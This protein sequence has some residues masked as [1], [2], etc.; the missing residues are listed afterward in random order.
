M[1][2]NESD[3]HNLKVLKN[4]CLQRF[5]EEQN[6]LCCDGLASLAYS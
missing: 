5:Q 1:K 2:R 6:I 3:V 4:I